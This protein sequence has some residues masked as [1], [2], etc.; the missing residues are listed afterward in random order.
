MS[1][2]ISVD[3][4]RETASDHH[5]RVIQHGIEPAPGGQQGLE[6][7][8]TEKRLY[9]LLTDVLQYPQILSKISKLMRRSEENK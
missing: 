8:E 1:L 3:E 9:S 7:S 5:V 4:A 6:T 2:L